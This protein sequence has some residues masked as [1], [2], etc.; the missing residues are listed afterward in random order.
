MKIRSVPNSYNGPGST[1]GERRRQA[2][3]VKIGTGEG[4]WKS[5]SIAG[6]RLQ[7]GIISD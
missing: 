5:G 3:A 4:D 2:G 6:L 1:C 7:T